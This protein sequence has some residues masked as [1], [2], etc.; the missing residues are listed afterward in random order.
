MSVSKSLDFKT[1][2]NKPCTCQRHEIWTLEDCAIE[3]II[4]KY[5]I[6][7]KELIKLL[8]DE[9]IKLYIRAPGTWS[10]IWTQDLKRLEMLYLNEQMVNQRKPP[11]KTRLRFKS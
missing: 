2:Y 11:R 4:N 3:H 10:L 8:S 5:C 6:R 9:E 1:Y 7:H